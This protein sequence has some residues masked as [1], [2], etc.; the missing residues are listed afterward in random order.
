MQIEQLASMPVEL[1]PPTTTTV[2][3][4]AREAPPGPR[5]KTL[6][7]T[8]LRTR[9]TLIVMAAVGLTLV[10]AK[11][12]WPEST[13][14]KTTAA[15][16]AT[17]IEKK[18]LAAAKK[19]VLVL[20]AKAA[21]PAEAKPEEKVA[22]AAAAAEKPTASPSPTTAPVGGVAKKKV[23]R[24][25]P[26]NP[27]GPLYIDE[28]NGFSIRFPAGW[29]IRTFNGDPWVIDAGDARVG[30]IS[31]GF[32]PFPDGFTTESIPPDMIARK[33]KRR[34]DTTLHAQGYGMIGGRKAL[35]SKSTGPLP[36]SHA[37]PRMTRVNY[38]LPLGDGRVL[39]LRVAAAPELFDKLVP[40][41][42]KAVETFALHTPQRRE[43]EPIASA[44]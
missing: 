35:W 17:T 13:Q 14:P 26:A 30:L 3:D 2:A 34:D 39:E 37:S 9:G 43:R 42:R 22:G 5:W 31:I 27:L 28:T 20:K 11:L 32:A 7:R 36:M 23:T 44:R 24:T 29:L 25:A 21:P 8:R 10:G 40:V 16:T 19:P 4:A 41:M 1:P 33:I 38:I 18:P 6:L 15:A 12:F